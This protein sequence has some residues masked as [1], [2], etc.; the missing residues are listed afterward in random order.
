MRAGGSARAW[1]GAAA[2]RA[3]SIGAAE[4]G[5]GVF[6]GLTLDEKVFDGSCKQ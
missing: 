2:S 5:G 1:S 4:I 3:A 6:M